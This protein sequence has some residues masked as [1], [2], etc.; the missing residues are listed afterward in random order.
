MSWKRDFLI[1]LSVV[2][3]CCWISSPATW[4]MGMAHMGSGAAPRQASQRGSKISTL[5]VCLDKAWAGVEPDWSK[6]P[7]E[8][9]SWIFFWDFMA[10]WS[11]LWL[12]GLFV[13]A[14]I[15]V[16]M[17][18]LCCLVGEGDWV[19]SGYSG[20]TAGEDGLNQEATTSSLIGTETSCSGPTF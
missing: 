11:C 7:P 1:Y 14:S 18:C 12:H 10:L 9:S 6:W 15:P 8:S 13:W 3:L 19:V 17:C 4:R 20:T 16:S 5:Q 2:G